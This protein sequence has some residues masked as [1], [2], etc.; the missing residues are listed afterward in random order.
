MEEKGSKRKSSASTEK[1]GE[2]ST[3]GVEEKGSKRKNATTP[4]KKVEEIDRKSL[5]INHDSN[6][7]VEIEV[8]TVP[9]PKTSPKPESGSVSP[10]TGDESD[11]SEPL[12]SPKESS[13]SNS[14][15]HTKTRKKKRNS[16]HH[17]EKSDDDK[18]NISLPAPERRERAFSTDG[19]PPNTFV[20]PKDDSLT[21][22]G[23][24]SSFIVFHFL[25]LSVCS[26]AIIMRTPSVCC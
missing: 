21:R 19:L 7:K 6:P 15:S 4:E 26:F 3:L 24:L 1:K 2:D 13:R 17:R 5:A 23:A 12:T 20:Q 9:S 16:S 22:T 8:S 11:A 10:S 25:F 14:K 18:D